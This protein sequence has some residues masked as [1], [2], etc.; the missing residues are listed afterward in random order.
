M[1][2]VDLHMCIVV[3]MFMQMLCFVFQVYKSIKCDIMKRMGKCTKGIFCAFAHDDGKT[4]LL[5]LCTMTSNFILYI[6]R[7]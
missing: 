5:L 1:L 6:S 4:L 7:K 3:Y 2:N